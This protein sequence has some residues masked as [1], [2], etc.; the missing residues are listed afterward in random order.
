VVP[1]GFGA[2][3]AAPTTSSVATLQSTDGA[4]GSSTPSSQ[5]VM[6]VAG[7]IIGGVAFISLAA[8]FLW[9]FRRRM[10]RKRRSTLLTPLT[11]NAPSSGGRRRGRGDRDGDREKQTPYEFDRGS[12]GPTATL[13]KFR[14]VVAANM[15]RVKGRMRR[16][17][18]STVNMDRGNSQFGMPEEQAHGISSGNAAIAPSGYED[19]KVTFGEKM[20]NFWTKVKEHR[21]PVMGAVALPFSIGLPNRLRNWRRMPDEDDSR[22]MAQRQRSSSQPDFLTLL[23]MD[24]R[25][26]D[27]EAQRARVSRNT[28]SLSSSDRFMGGLNLNFGAERDSLNPFHDANALPSQGASA[29]APQQKEPSAFNEQRQ[30]RMSSVPRQPADYVADI[31]RSRGQSVGGAT[32]RAPSTVYGGGRESLASVQTFNTRRNKFR[33]DPF[34]LEPALLGTSPPGPVPSLPTGGI[35][36]NGANVAAAAAGDAGGRGRMQS[37]TSSTGGTYGSGTNSMASAPGVRKP[38]NA[39][40]RELSVG[41]MS[42]KYSS[43][44][45]LVSAMSRESMGDW[46]DPGPDVGAGGGGDAVGARAGWGPNSR[47]SPTQGWRDRAEKEAAAQGKGKRQS[48]GSQ[49]SAGSAA[50][51]GVGKAY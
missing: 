19:E 39:H 10:L 49:K 17:T 40:T 4:G 48:G 44:I 28:G 35:S 18:V 50:T 1:I 43:G 34:D 12:I 51:T 16:D 14:A 8:V 7:S 32:T 24:D 38:Q 26:L 11:D 15:A 6:T 5:S 30:R 21:L 45:S 37:R 23:S 47:E 2:D 29:P 33:S 22:D 9:F 36:L 25:E 3:G 31:R 13:N 46:S 20:H 42:S 27:R 41:G